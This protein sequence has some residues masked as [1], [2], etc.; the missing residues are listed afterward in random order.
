M[1]AKGWLGILKRVAYIFSRVV[2]TKGVELG[3]G[4]GLV[5]NQR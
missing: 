4:S 1:V 5:I 2:I 3:L